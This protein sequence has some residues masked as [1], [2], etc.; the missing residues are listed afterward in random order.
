MKINYQIFALLL[1]TLLLFNSYQSSSQEANWTA[2]ASDKFS[3]KYSSL[4]QI[5]KENVKDVGIKWTWESPDNELKDQFK[6]PVSIYQVTPIAIEGVL[7]VSS[8]TAIV[9]AINGVTGETIWTYDPETY[10]S[11]APAHG[12]YIHRGVSFWDDGAAGRIIFGTPDA[13]LIALNANDGSLVSSFGEGGIVDLSK[14]LSREFDPSHYGI[15]TPPVIANDVIVIGASITDASPQSMRPPG[16][17]RGFDVKTGEQL[18]VFHTIPA[19][20]EFGS[21]T[22]E[23]DARNV[24]GNTNV[25]TRMSADEE[26]GYVYLPISTPT[27]DWYGGNRLGDNLFAESLVC[28]NTRTGKRI[29]HFQMVHHGIWDYDLPAAPNL[30]NINRE[31]ETVKAVAQVSK[32]GFTYVFNRET[33]EPIWP[34]EERPVPQSTVPG[35]RTSPTQPFPSKPAPFDRQGVTVDDI[36]DFTPEIFD[37]A[38]TSLNDVDTG[39]L[40]TPPTEKG[41]IYVPG[42]LGGANWHGAAVDPE[43]GVLYIP[44]MTFPSMFKII[45][46][47]STKTDANYEWERFSIKGPQGLPLLK[48]PYGRITAIDLNTGN[49]IWQ[50]ALGEGPRNHPLLKDLNLPRLGWNLRGA[51]LLTKT[52]LF[53]GQEGKYW[54]YVPALVGGAKLSKVA[55]DE[56][57]KFDPKIQVFDK[58]NGTLIH[59]IELPYNVTGAPMTYSINGKQFIAFAVGGSIGP[60]KIIALGL[61]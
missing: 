31:G 32:Q 46:S 61:K 21:E 36:I 13:R 20:D 3:S 52:L 47:D 45:K 17:V 5:N 50:S 44:S 1:L 34:I 38:W 60:A 51:P 53:V 27:N 11:N 39:E 33:G 6:F 58:D 54:E 14:G 57:I 43:S 10:K 37:E 42:A 16:D 40:F 22:W 4:D 23:G 12:A 41:L 2:Y 30:L 55:T 26:L 28:L 15:S 19:E 49:H 8:S 29:W 7:Y 24:T 9:S 18:W 56:I 35:E 59:E 48:P 25:W